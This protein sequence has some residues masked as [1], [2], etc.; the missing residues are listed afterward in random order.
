MIFLRN[1][2]CKSIFRNKEIKYYKIH[3]DSINIDE[4]TLITMNLT[5]IEVPSIT[6]Y[7]F[8]PI[9]NINEDIIIPV[10]ITDYNN[11]DYIYN[12][13]SK[14]FTVY[15]ELEGKT[16][17]EILKIGDNNINLG[18]ISYET[19]THIIIK[20]RDNET[21]MESY[22]QTIPVW[23]QDPNNHIIDDSNTYTMQESDLEIYSIKNN[24]SKESA[25]LIS[26]RKGLSQF[27]QDK[28]DEGYK[29]VI[30]IENS[31]FRMD[32][33]TVSGDGTPV[34]IP[35]NMTVDMNGSTFRISPES[36]PFVSG[37]PIV[38]NGN[39][40]NTCLE[41]GILQGSYK[42][43]ESLEGDDWDTFPNNDSDGNIVAES[44]GS[45]NFSGGQYNTLRNMVV[46]NIEGYSITGNA[47]KDVD[48]L[49]VGIAT[50]TCKSC[51]IKNGEE[52]TDQNMTTTNM[53]AIPTK[54]K[55]KGFLCFNRFKGYAGYT[56]NDGLEFFS[57]Y[58][59]NQEYI[60][61]TKGHQM[62]ENRIPE[63]AYYVRITLFN[64]LSSSTSAN[65][66]FLQS[67]DLPTHVHIENVQNYN[68][69]TCSITSSEY[70]FLRI[71]QCTFTNCGKHITPAWLDLE[72]GYESGHNLYLDGCTVVDSPSTVDCI[73]QYANNFVIENNT[74]ISF[75]FSNCK[76]VTFR[77][78]KTRK[79]LILR[80]SRMLY[81]G[82][83]RVYDNILYGNTE[84][85]NY[86]TTDTYVQYPRLIKNNEIHGSMI[87]FNTELGLEKIIGGTLIDGTVNGGIFENICVMSGKIS[88]DLTIF[89][90]SEINCSFG[91]FP[92][93]KF[94][95]CNFK[96]PTL[97]TGEYYNC[98]F[99]LIDLICGNSKIV[100][101]GELTNNTVDNIFYNTLGER[102]TSGEESVVIENC[103][104]NFNSTKKG[105]LV[106]LGDQRNKYANTHSTTFKNCVINMS[107]GTNIMNAYYDCNVSWL[108]T[109]IGYTVNFINCTIN[110][111]Y[112]ELGN[113]ISAASDR[114]IINYINE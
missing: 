37:I 82:F 58:D 12:N 24:D 7:Y 31:I 101:C 55:N 112:T 35:E 41:N 63:N 68:T 51:Y 114:Y 74:D 22:E 92:T 13:N 38:T 94:Y 67:L 5:S 61:T 8:D 99:N 9:F 16:K 52:I 65:H 105:S 25:D 62:R 44:A 48:T 86:S 64:D 113:N 106:G 60:K 73:C 96:T 83:R 87:S 84:M 50:T 34:I 45:Y 77:N 66:A 72:D 40:S 109:D 75:S 79:T 39:H 97:V 76:N 54:I 95:N 42:Y 27:L 49:W 14:T 69:R 26:T 80:K 23:V 102:F 71:Y 70:N 85:S 59:E 78:N 93:T 53:I 108:P 2:K 91:G 28:S 1:T 46:K 43:D 18:S 3:K 47:G 110:G 56:G 21:G 103:T 17:T 98:N 111:N 20:C 90:N 33:S 29:K 4:D 57:W 107:D 89:K 36:E 81:H 11:S 15:T 100:D 32:Y 10:Y 6:C 104:I 30:L 88:R 19:K